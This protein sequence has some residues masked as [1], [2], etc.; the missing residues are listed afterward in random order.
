MHVHTNKNKVSDKEVKSEKNYN[1]KLIQNASNIVE[2][3]K[4]QRKD[5]ATMVLN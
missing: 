5:L 3:L 1:Q 2:E 4:P